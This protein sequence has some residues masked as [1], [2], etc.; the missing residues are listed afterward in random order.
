MTWFLVILIS[1][2]IIGGTLYYWKNKQSQ[3]IE[4]GDAIKR[5]NDFAMQ[6]HVFTT[7]IS[8]LTEI[9]NTMNKGVLT[10]HK[11]SFEPDYRNGKIVFHNNSFG[12][13]FGAAL[14]DLGVDEEQ[15]HKYQFQVEA[16]NGSSKPSYNDFIAAN[17]LLTEI[18]RTL[19]KLDDDTKINRTYAKYKTNTKWF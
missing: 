10:N 9:G 17:V 5:N 3:T 19:L 2:A 8:D 16:W 1:V 18:E 13:S 14:R 11:I 6:K 12:G 4:S 15:K 7:A